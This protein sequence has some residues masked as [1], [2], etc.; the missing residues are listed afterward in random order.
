MKK[1]YRIFVPDIK[2]LT[3]NKE[4]KLTVKDLNPGRRKYT[5]HI[6][7]AIVSSDP[8]TM[9]DGDILQ[10]RSW[11]GVLYPEPWAITILEEI[12]ETEA[13]V[14]HG[15]TIGAGQNKKS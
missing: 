6:V 13:G 1:E 2:D 4:I 8:G 14:P 12:G 11:T 7:R 9:P 10:V 3:E 15:E 5:A